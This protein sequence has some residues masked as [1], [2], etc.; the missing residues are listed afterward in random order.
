V[1]WHDQTFAG[2]HQAQATPCGRVDLNVVRIVVADTQ[3]RAEIAF[4][5]Y[6]TGSTNMLPA[7]VDQC[8]K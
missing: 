4:R 7:S 5:N 1:P 2:H 6:R 3:M 8:R